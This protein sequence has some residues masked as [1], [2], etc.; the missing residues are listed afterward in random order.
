MGFCGLLYLQCTAGAAEKLPFTVH[1][2]RPGTLCSNFV[3]ITNVKTSCSASRDISEKLEE[4]IMGHD[5]PKGDSSDHVT[6][7]EKH[8]GLW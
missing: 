4:G 7:H 8:L 2:L 5:L 3:A 1:C 6:L